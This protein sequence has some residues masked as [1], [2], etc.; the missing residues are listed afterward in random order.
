MKRALPRT[1]LDFPVKHLIKFAP[2]P[3]T[4]KVSAPDR[5]DRVKYGGYLV[6]IAN[7]IE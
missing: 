3:V 7:C 4:A 6:K 1:E 2:K 5:S